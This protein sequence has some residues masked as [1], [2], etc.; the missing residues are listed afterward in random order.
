MTDRLSINGAVRAELGT[1]ASKRI[2]KDN[3]I[4]AVIYGGKEKNQFISLPKKEI[5]KLYLTGNLFT[6]ILDINING[7]TI[8][9]LP[10]EID[11]HPVNNTPRHI[12]LVRIEAEKL[13]KAKVL[14]KFM[15]RERSPGIK[16]GGY[17]NIIYRR[18]ELMC[19]PENIPHIISINIGKMI[20]GNKVKISNLQ[21]PEGVVPASKKDLIIA[22][23]IGRKK[24]KEEEEAK[25]G[26][27]VEGSAE[28]STEAVGAEAA[29]TPAKKQNNENK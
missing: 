15:G 6:T 7:K 8:S 13:V 11:N 12:D 18:L 28:A 19:N 23:M 4:P 10:H 26:E 25:E 22:S 21:L 24:E 29:E 1:P 20:I 27:S 3:M 9:V 16:K 14:L 5:N 17:L 2:R